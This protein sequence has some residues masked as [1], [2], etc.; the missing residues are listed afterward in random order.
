MFELNGTYVIFIASFLVFI[1]LLNEIMLKPVGKVI[2]ERRAQ[3]EA[4]VEESKKSRQEA[5][6]VLVQYQ[7]RLSETRGEAQRIVNEAL[8]KAQRVRDEKVKEVQ[9]EGRKRLE[10]AKAE[11]ASERQTL[12]DGLVE[13]EIELVKLINHKLMGETSVV[14]LDKEKVRRALEEAC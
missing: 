12:I 14:T 1:F 7:N 10:K 13:Q 6:V 8:V 2:A 11:L 4:N 9:E 3:I 5:D